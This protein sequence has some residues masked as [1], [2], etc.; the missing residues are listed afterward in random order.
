MISKSLHF[1]AQNG[2]KNL[3]YMKNRFF[4]LFLTFFLVFSAV[5][6]SS[7]S[8][9]TGCPMNETVN[10][11][12]GKNGQMSKKRGKSNLFPKGMRKKRGR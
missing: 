11:K 9:K 10:T 6:F 5:S 2:A 8:Q 3:K 1:N 7:C 4:L 12:A